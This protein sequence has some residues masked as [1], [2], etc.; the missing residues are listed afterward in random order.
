MLELL[1]SIGYVLSASTIAAGLALLVWHV[2]DLARKLGNNRTVSRSAAPLL[3]S[4]RRANDERV[5]Q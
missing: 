2:W 3:G 4:H 5:Q 1:F